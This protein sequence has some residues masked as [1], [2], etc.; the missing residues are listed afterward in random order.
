MPR[1][2]LPLGRQ[3]RVAVLAR[4]VSL[5]LERPQ[6]TSILNILPARVEEVRPDGDTLLMVRL[7][8][9]GATLLSRITRRSGEALEIRPGR[10]LFAQVKAVALLR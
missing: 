6:R 2:D 10:E 5:A 4:D 1:H 9:G 3:V 7:D 8:V